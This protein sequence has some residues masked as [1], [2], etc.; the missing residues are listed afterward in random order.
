M[1]FRHLTSM[2]GV[3]F[4]N[5]TFIQQEV[6]EKSSLVCIE[7][8]LWLV[9]FDQIW[10]I[11][12]EL[13]YCSFMP[14]QLFEAVKS[15]KLTRLLVISRAFSV[16][17]VPFTSTF[18]AQVP[19]NHS[20]IL[21]ISLHSDFFQCSPFLDILF[22]HFLAIFFNTFLFLPCGLQDCPEHSLQLSERYFHSVKFT[23][24]YKNFGFFSNRKASAFFTHHFGMKRLEM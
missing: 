23:K 24:L 2:P 10:Q 8:V 14:I 7:Y 12:L 1:Q 20:K 17:I 15:L 21:S 9:F 16:S 3:S 19:L 18:A 5:V 13:F 6:K 4:S 11:F 22:T